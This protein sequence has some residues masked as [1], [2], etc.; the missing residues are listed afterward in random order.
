MAAIGKR[1]EIDLGITNS[2]VAI[3]QGSNPEVLYSAEGQPHISSAVSLRTRRGRGGEVRRQILVG[4]AAIANWEHAPEDTIVSIRRLIGLGVADPEVQRLKDWLLYK[5]VEPSDGA[6]D[7]IRVVMGGQEYSPVD[8]SAMILRKLKEDAEFRLGEEVTHAVITVPAYFGQAR[9]AA[10]RMA[11]LKAGLK[12]TKILAE[13][14]AVAM[15]YGLDETEDTEPKNILVYDLGD[16][17]FD[18]SVLLTWGPVFVTM[19]REGDI[20]LGG[21][22]FDRAAVECALESIREEYGVDPSSDLRF[23]V[24]LKKAAQK[25]R[26]RLSTADWTELGVPGRLKDEAGFVIDVFV[27]ITREKYEQLIRP[28]VERSLRLVDKAIKNAEQL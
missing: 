15:S 13:P 2:V 19:N 27:E 3:M 14:T 22:D 25:A 23:M 11:G 20:W 1:V 4:D 7:S 26:E 12:V 18:I 9:R 24:A 6:R 17:T 10:T 28:L 5:V 16:G 21:D 8:I